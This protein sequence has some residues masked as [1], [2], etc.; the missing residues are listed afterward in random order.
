MS[1][2]TSSRI[3]E[4]VA[5][6]KRLT[7]GEWATELGVSTSCIRCTLTSLRRKGHRLYPIGGSYNKP[8]ILTDIML[9]ESDA[10]AT[11]HRLNN[12]FVRPAINSFLGLSEQVVEEYKSLR[13]QQMNLISGMIAQL[14]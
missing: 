14:G 8:G 1:Y 3:I 9:K 2:S 12:R 4:G 5:A 6:G 7:C 13:K 11:M 10:N